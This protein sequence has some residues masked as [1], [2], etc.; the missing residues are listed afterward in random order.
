MNEIVAVLGLP[1]VGAV[2]L[3]LV[4]HQR[5]A[6]EVNVAASLGTLVAAAALTFRVIVQG[7][8]IAL[9]KLFFVDPFN[10]FLVAL[11]AFVA[12]VSFALAM[13]APTNA[14][15]ATWGQISAA[16]KRSQ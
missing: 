15:I 1:L 2:A 6:A 3:A 14:F 11:T 10:V 9:D 12:K 5:F 7:P 16:M 4:G 13:G 8:F